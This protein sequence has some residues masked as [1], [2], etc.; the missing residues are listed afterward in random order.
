MRFG[1]AKSVH[2]PIGIDFGADSIK[3]LQL[4]ATSPPQ[5]LAAAAMTLLDEA[6]ADPAARH[7]FNLEAITTLVRSQKFKGRR[8]IVSIPA[9]YTLVQHLQLPPGGA[10]DD[11]HAQI[12]LHLLQRMNIDP[13]RLVIRHTYVGDVVRDGS[14]RQEVLCIA[15]ARD[16]VMRHIEAARQARLE[17][18]GMHAEP[19][20]ILRAFSHLNANTGDQKRT[21][22]FV[23]I[24]AATT[25]VV[26]AQNGRMVFAKNIHAAGDQITRHFAKA[27]GI[28]FSEARQMRLSLAES[29]GR[30]GE[31]AAVS[32]M[33]SPA[34]VGA[35]ADGGGEGPSGGSGF[36]MIDAQM[37][38]ADGG[39][40]TG[41]DRPS[42]D[43]APTGDTLDCII[44][45]MR[46]C[47]RYYQCVLPDSPIQNLV[48][49]G[50][51]SRHVDMCQKI[52]R[53]MRIGA[54]LGD[55]LA[56]VVRMNLVQP[57][58]GVDLNQP[59]PGWTVPMGLCLSEPNI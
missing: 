6:R 8:A 41:A 31:A 1:L 35:A 4:S 58:R 42:P 27:K 55:P 29:T 10:E 37:R 13:S 48:F 54:Q 7:A 36:A 3:L 44:D 25:K 18:V 45:E 9:H 39:A 49:V 47:A 40:T 15:V 38:A 43:A 52:A 12:E 23:D 28:L 11:L 21:T 14:T 33:A 34:T 26:I 53:A 32:A 17:V 22:C 20:A 50:G 59:Q 24:G 57:P 56:R 51:Q 16:V 5:I 2:S 19:H 46:L 30:A